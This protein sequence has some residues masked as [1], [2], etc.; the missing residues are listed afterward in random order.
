MV[1]GLLA[2]GPLQMLFSL[3]LMRGLSLTML[4]TFLSQ[5]IPRV[6]PMRFSMNL[7]NQITDQNKPSSTS[8][9]LPEQNL[10]PYLQ[11]LAPMLLQQHLQQQQQRQQPM[12]S[13]AQPLFQTMQAV[14]PIQ[15]VQ[16]VQSVQPMQVLQP[17]QQAVQAMQPVQ[18]VQT[19]QAI[20][21]RV[22]TA[23]VIHAQAYQIPLMNGVQMPQLIIVP[24]MVGQQQSDKGSASTN[25]PVQVEA[26]HRDSD[27]ED[28]GPSIQNSH[29]LKRPPKTTRRPKVVNRAH[30][31]TL[32]VQVATPKAPAG[33]RRFIIAPVTANIGNDIDQSVSTFSY[34]RELSANG[35]STSTLS[36]IDESEDS[37]VDKSDERS[38]ESETSTP[39]VD[40]NLIESNDLLSAIRT[41]SEPT[42]TTSSVDTTSVTSDQM[43][44]NELMNRTAIVD[45]KASNETKDDSMEAKESSDVSS[46]PL[47]D[48]IHEDYIRYVKNLN[49]HRME[50]DRGCRT[51]SGSGGAQE[52]NG[53]SSSR[54][55]SGGGLFRSMG[56]LLLG[57]RK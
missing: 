16:P 44:G 40:E 34:D 55:S 28:G 12:M 10:L 25:M 22:M 7:G 31:G 52:G 24:Q 53:R 19:V 13:S 49:N 20:Q 57:N 23:P 14:Q 27:Q 48:Q 50:S 39:S 38:A 9:P 21:P 45:N 47:T 32:Y 15:A 26:P 37:A 43:T 6:D 11:I 35:Y 1:L 51:V 33:F 36:T 18:T 8:S 54:A 4:G 17:L 5:A 46:K 56:R 30:A 42:I 3:L 29:M 2:S 41:T